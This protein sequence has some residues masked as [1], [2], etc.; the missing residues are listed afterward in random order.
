MHHSTGATLAPKEASAKGPRALSANIAAPKEVTVDPTVCKPSVHSSYKAVSVD[1]TNGFS[2]NGFGPLDAMK[3]SEEAFLPLDGDNVAG[4]RPS[5]PTIRRLAT[6]KVRIVSSQERD[7]SISSKC[8][9]HGFGPPVLALG[10]LTASTVPQGNGS[11]NGEVRLVHD[12]RSSS[13]K[14]FGP[15]GTMDLPEEV[16]HKE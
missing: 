16:V 14:R 10:C 2:T 1:P 11:S 7:F 12:S 5:S 15:L 8:P 13:P 3:L 9:A 6:E 4:P